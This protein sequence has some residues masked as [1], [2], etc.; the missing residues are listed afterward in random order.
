MDRPAEQRFGR[1]D[2]GICQNSQKN[3]VPGRCL[4][5]SAPVPNIRALYC[6]ERCRQIAELVRYARR[7]IAERVFT[8]PDIAEAVAIR[9]SQLVRGFYDKRARK[10]EKDLRQ[11]LLLRSGGRCENCGNNFT[12]EGDRKFTVQHI[13]TDHGFELQ[14][15]CYRCNMNHAQSVPVDCT[16]DDL[17]FF[18]AFDARVQADRPVLPCDDHENWPRLYKTLQVEFRE[19][20][21]EKNQPEPE[22]EDDYWSV[23]DDPNDPE[24]G[25][26]FLNDMARDD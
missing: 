18:A 4:N 26:Y 7:K 8:R 14:A 1:E 6:S 24:S 23:F 5:C 10:V 20:W 16:E 22:C 12:E 21:L 15:W 19:A 11:A 25:S 9:C 3:Y 17:A 2:S 13:S